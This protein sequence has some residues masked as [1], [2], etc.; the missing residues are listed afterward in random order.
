MIS[1]Y[2]VLVGDCVDSLRKLGDNEINCCVTSPPYYGL[3]DYGV[4][5]QIG[6]EKT[7]TEYINKLVTVF[8]EIKRVLRD[9]GV[10]WINIGD[11]YAG[12][13]K[14]AWNNKEAQIEK[15]VA[16][17]QGP[18]SKMPRVW[19]EIGIKSKDLI[20]IPWMLAFALRN[21]G[22]Y[23]R[24]DIIWHKPN[25]MPSSVKDRCTTAHEYLFLLSKSNKY[26]F[27]NESILEKAA[28]STK[29]QRGRRIRDIPIQKDG[30]FLRNKRSVW[31]INTRKYRGSHFAVFPPKLIEPCILSS[32]P[33]GGIVLDPFGGTGTTAGVA[34]ANDRK[35]IICE[36]NPEYVNLIPQRI[37]SIADE[38]KN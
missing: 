31:S 24:Q 8:R 14:G 38:Y 11:T 18:Q 17:P 1:D 26:Y 16:D 34:I 20:G 30:E 13:G 21:D 4:D 37:K 5:G 33:V 32:C 29:K 10:L 27:N 3:R 19:K 9:D 23:L 36:L 12:S 28:N 22:W 15:Y 2:T 25:A 7:P 6:L 35:A